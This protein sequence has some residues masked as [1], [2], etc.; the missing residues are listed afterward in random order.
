MENVTAHSTKNF[1][2]EEFLLQSEFAKKLYFDYAAHLPI[3]DYHNHLSPKD[4]SENRR[5]ENPTQVW[6]EGDHYKWRAMRT[7][8]IDEQY[9]SGTAS[10]KE[11]FRKWSQT[12]PYAIRNPLYHWTHLELQR[13]FDINDLLT[14]ATSD[15]IYDRISE[16][17]KD[18]SNDTVGL[19]N[20]VNVEVV[21]TTDD[22]IDTLKSHLSFDTNESSFKLLPTF[23]PD[24]IFQTDDSEVFNDYVNQLAV[25][26]NC[27]IDTYDNL[28]EAYKDRIAYFHGAGCKLSDHGLEQLYFFRLGTYSI[29]SIFQKLRAYQNIT[30]Q[31]K[32]YFIFETLF[33]LC[34][35]YRKNGWVQQFHLGALRNTNVRM[36]K[37]IGADSGFDSIGDFS[38]AISLS[39]FLNL[40]DTENQLAKTVIYNLNP[41]YNEVFA[42][43]IGNFNDG[44]IKGKIQYGT[45]WWFLDQ[46]DGIK[47]QLDALSNLSL[48]SCFIGMVTDSR[49]FLSFP[50]HEY[51]RRILCNIIAT[52]VKN[53]ELPE[54]EKWL[55]KIVADICYHNAK[56]YFQF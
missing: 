19:L 45:A 36:Y 7:L 22:P 21:C 40:L 16:A 6:L 53:G 8:G 29:D 5:F 51:F 42:A 46:K 26:S 32:Q 2:T 14:P 38:Q 15:H 39:N 50:R 33:H 31:E 27:R 56:Q 37:T 10:D 52:D 9:I 17:L 44:S 13:Y 23:R 25:V 41:S 18:E 11:K 20:K 4:I 35:E 1:I 12:V 49:S 43:M 47:K 24:R 54:D 55:G 3:I 48:L 34:K 28:L 30:E